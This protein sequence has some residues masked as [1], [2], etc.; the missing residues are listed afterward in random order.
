M[1]KPSIYN[2]LFYILIKY[3]VFY[4]LMMFK[5]NN[6]YL[7][8]PGIRDVVDLYYYLWLFLFLPIACILLFSGPIYFAFRLKKPIYFSLIISAFWIAEYFVYT[9]LAS[10]LNWINGL[11][12][13]VISVL[14]LFLF[15]FNYIKLL[16]I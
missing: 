7:I 10:P 16:F 8:S 4:V 6:F 9:Y 14:F 3:L 13:G 2:I 1:L 11:Y 15:F 5:S 12:N